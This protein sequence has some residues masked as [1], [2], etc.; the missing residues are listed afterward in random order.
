MLNFYKNKSKYKIILTNQSSLSLSDC[1]FLIF[2]ILHIYP[3]W[4]NYLH[5][6]MINACS[7]AINQELIS[8]I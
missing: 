6:I 8:N 1:Y 2:I 7:I 5:N 4:L 3:L